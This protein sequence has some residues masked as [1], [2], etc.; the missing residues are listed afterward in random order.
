MDANAIDHTP[1][2]S[3]ESRIFGEQLG[4]ARTSR[5]FAIIHIA[6]FEAVNAIAGG[7][8]SYVGL[9]C[10]SPDTSMEAAVAQAAHD[11]L[12][13]MFP[14]QT[15]RFDDL[16]A[17]DLSAL[18][19]D[20]AK[21]NGI[22]VGQRAGAAILAL[23][24]GDGSDRPEPR[25]G[26]DFMTSNKPGRWRQDPISQSPLA[27]GAYWGDVRPF[28]LSTAS[29]L[30]V[31]RPPALTSVPYTLAFNEVKAFGGDGVTTFTV[32]TRDQTFAAI[33][34]GY[35]GTPGLGTPPRLYNQIAVQIAGQMGSNVVELA[36]LLALVNVAL[37]DAG[38]ACWESKYY[39]Q[40]WRPIAGIRESDWGTG[41]TGAGDG[42]LLTFGDP[43][44]TPLGAPASNLRGP[45]FTPPFPSYPSGHATFGGAFFQILRYVYGTDSI[46]FTFVSDEFNGVTRDNRGN[47]RPRM[48]RS[49][50][51]FSQAEEENGQSRIYLGIHWAFDKTAGIAQ[52]RRV[53]DCVFSNAFVPTS[54]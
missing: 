47:V 53:A 7:Y 50:S 22:D 1:P 4:P 26:I 34:W 51:S 12:A 11:T 49:F 25:I 52:G 29:Q 54:Y 16:L 46:A 8:Q 32:R 28:V 48:A 24:A 15:P 35:D 42:N 21:A 18:P 2:P 38:I 9:D 3:G 43:N 30:R 45:N 6:I 31:S 27:L 14:S 10:A 40:F 19:D 44:F 17:E 5:A 23:R 37:A 33:Y 36:R 39:Y 13:A 20:A 41:P